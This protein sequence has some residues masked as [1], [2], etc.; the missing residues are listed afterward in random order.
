MLP[1]GEVYPAGQ[2]VHTEL[3]VVPVYVPAAQ[4]VQAL[5]PVMSLYV[6]AAQAVHVPAFGPVYPVLQ[7]QVCLVSAVIESAGQ[8][9]QTPEVVAP[10]TVLYKLT[11]QRVQLTPLP[12]EFFQDPAEHWVHEPAGPVYPARQTH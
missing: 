6:P 5:L 8:L 4:L 10:T 2:A 7:K 11:A 1:N 12:M 3:P 9:T